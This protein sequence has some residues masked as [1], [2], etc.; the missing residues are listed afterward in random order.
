M[1]YVGVD[2]H[3]QII[4]LCVVKVVAGKRQVVARRTGSASGE[5]SAR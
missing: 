2:L 5:R 1:K 3:K 4:V